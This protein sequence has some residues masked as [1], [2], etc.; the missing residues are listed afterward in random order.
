MTVSAH[1]GQAT[2]D[3]TGAQEVGER[4]RFRVRLRAAATV[5]LAGLLLAGCRAPAD[6]QVRG[7][8]APDAASTVSRS[9]TGCVDGEFYW[10]RPGCRPASLVDVDE[11]LS[12]GPPPDGIPPIDAPIFESTESASSWLKD[13]SPVM[14]VEDGGEIHAY[15]LAILT[16]HEIVND[17]IGVV[18]VVVTYCPLCNS[19]LAFDRTVEGEVLDFGTS[20]RL[21]RSNLVM[22]DRQERNLWL[23]FTGTAVVGER[24][25]GRRLRRMPSSLLGFRELREIAPDARV[26]SRN[27][28]HRRDYGRNPYLGYDTEHGEPFLYEGPRDTRLEPMTRVVGLGEHAPVAITLTRLRQAQVVEIEVDGAPIVVFWAPGQTSGLEGSSLDEGRDVGQTSAFRPSTPDGTRLRFQADG[29]GGFL[30]ATGT[31]WDLLGRAVS[32]PLAGT[33]LDP[34]AHDDTFWFVWYA[35][36]P[37]TTLQS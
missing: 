18:P 4:E 34:V 5:S 36:R 21:Y 20:G 31:T 33:R 30:D 13:E 2:H 14:V 17:R 35:F 29:R 3:R 26:L 27:T 25:L 24:F 15:P 23:Q 1:H 28:G 12:G 8:R 7:A 22:Y 6:E 9:S 19:G 10:E 16:W 32:G 11:I 37:Q